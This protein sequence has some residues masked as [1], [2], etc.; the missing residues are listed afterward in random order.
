MD[1]ESDTE[2]S[3]SELDFV[4]TDNRYLEYESELSHAIRLSKIEAEETEKKKAAEIERNVKEAIMEVHKAKAITD[5][6]HNE[7]NFFIINSGWIIT[8]II[9]YL[10]SAC[11]S[12]LK[13]KKWCPHWIGCDFKKV[14]PFVMTCKKISEVAI[15]WIKE[16]T[17]AYSINDR[18]YAHLSATK[19]HCTETIKWR[20]LG[21]SLDP[22]YAK[23]PSIRKH[24]RII[25]GRDT[26]IK[27]YLGHW[28]DSD[29]S[30]EEKD[31]LSHWKDSDESDE[32]IVKPEHSHKLYIREMHKAACYCNSLEWK[33]FISKPSKYNIAPFSPISEIFYSE[34][35]LVEEIKKIGF[36]YHGNPDFYEITWTGRNPN[37]LLRP[38]DSK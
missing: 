25:T 19:I 3:D 20:I 7:D 34:K 14:R 27:D 23:A 5:S 13:K 8:E 9:P 12:C 17:I 6:K 24:I 15:A 36:Q 4:F 26:L 16:N 29:G 1:S 28:K 30:D 22:R 21:W 32:K 31:D 2:L 11:S 33:L 38:L 10:T 18:N 37:K 35:D